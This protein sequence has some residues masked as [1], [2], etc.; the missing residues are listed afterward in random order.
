MGP[1]RALSLDGSSRE[2]SADQ[3]RGFGFQITHIRSL[4]KCLEV[5]ATKEGCPFLLH[6]I[7]L[8]SWCV[9]NARNQLFPHGPNMLFPPPH[10]W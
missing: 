8:L 5:G 3:S 1:G 6:L 2:T 10:S 7:S 4:N 9:G